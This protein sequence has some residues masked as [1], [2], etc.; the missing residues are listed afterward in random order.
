MPPRSSS[1]RQPGHRFSLR[2]QRQRPQPIRRGETC[3]ALFRDPNTGETSLAP[4]IAPM[5]EP[6]DPKSDDIKIDDADADVV[7]F[8]WRVS[9]NLTRRIDQYLVDRIG[10]LSRAGVQRVIADGMV[11]VNGRVIKASSHPREGDQIDMVAPPEPISELLP[12]PIPLD[13]IFEDDDFLALNKQADLIVHPARGR[14]TGTLVNGLVHYGKKWS[15][16]G[17][18]WR[19]GI[20]HRLDRNT[21]G[22]MLVAK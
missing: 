13:I 14:W 17:G 22:I 21:T 4:T 6:A 16:L 8:K 18:N 20:L 5:S 10:Y 12:E 3:L 1:R 9:K 19:P 15:M 2:S 11:K 7:H